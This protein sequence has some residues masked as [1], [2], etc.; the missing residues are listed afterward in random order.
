[1]TKLNNQYFNILKPIL[2]KM[3]DFFDCLGKISLF[4]F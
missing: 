4:I 3:K 1:M 2:Q